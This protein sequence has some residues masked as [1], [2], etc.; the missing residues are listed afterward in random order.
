[1]NYE[2]YTNM[3]TLFNPCT[4]IIIYGHIISIWMKS[5]SNINNE[6]YSVICQLLNFSLIYDI[7]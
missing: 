7:S 4:G 2:E 1:M 5:A 3:H 6:I